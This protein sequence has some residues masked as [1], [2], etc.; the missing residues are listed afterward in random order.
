MD[1]AQAVPGAV[2]GVEGPQSRT[3]PPAALGTGCLGPVALTLG[4]EEVLEGQHLGR[5]ITGG[6]RM[7]GLLFRV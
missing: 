4:G 2:E 6:Q 5:G 1:Q 7:E 3:T